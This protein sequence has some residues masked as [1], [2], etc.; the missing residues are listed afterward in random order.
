MPASYT[1]EDFV[2]I[3]EEYADTLPNKINWS[4]IAENIG[5]DSST[6]SKFRTKFVELRFSTLRKLTKLIFNNNHQ[7][8]FKKGCLTLKNKNNV[9][10]SLEYLS[11][12]RHLNELNEYIDLILESDEHSAELKNW[13]EL[14]RI[15]YLHQTDADLNL[16][17]DALRQYTPKFLETKILYEILTL[18][19][20][21]RQR[22]YKTMLSNAESIL[23]SIPNIKDSYIRDS[24]ECRVNELLAYVYLHNLNDVKKARFFANKVINCNEMSESFVSGVL[25]L[26]GVSYLFENYDTC[27]SYILKY[28]DV[29]E[30]VGRQ[31]HV[32]I[33]NTRDLPFIQN[34]CGVQSESKDGWDISE[35]AHFEA[36]YGNKE[37]AIEI[38]ESLGQDER[39]MTGFMLY[40]LAIAKN[41]M[42]IMMK[43]LI[44]FA[45]K[46]DMFYAQ[47]PFSYLKEDDTYRSMAEML[48]N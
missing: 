8:I 5:V 36:K 27:R 46:G 43:S 28:K 14:Y 33:V 39:E 38:I 10:C 12:N 3:F 16:F 45:K 21:F 48:I 31:N 47:L 23:F 19:H 41:D 26:A 1:I 17:K 4:Q 9:K 13:A 24:Y 44:K 6:I 25:Y 35:V 11:F 15:V 40:Y 18:Y 34:I 7:N 32:E 37:K 20:L 30:K 22:E 29:M 2:N 42:S